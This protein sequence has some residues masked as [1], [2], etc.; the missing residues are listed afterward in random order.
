MIVIA[1]KTEKRLKDDL[2]QLAKSKPNQ[3]CFYLGLSQTDLP[4]KTVFET[5]LKTVDSIPNSYMAKI[6]LCQDKDIL[7]VMEG[8]MQRQFTAFA[9]TF[10]DTLNH[11]NFDH[12]INVYEVGR[13]W[14][15]LEKICLNKIAVLDRAEAESAAIS[16]DDAADVKIAEILQTLTPQDIAT[17]SNR[18]LMRENSLVMIADDDQLTRTLAGNVIRADYD[19]VFAQNGSKALKD[20]VRAAPDILFLDIGMPDIGGHDVLETLFQ[21]DP[22]AYIIMFSGR[23]DKSTIMKSL[24]MGAHGFLGKPFTR[25]QIYMHIENS[26]F[27]QANINKAG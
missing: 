9:G 15:T 4:R 13:H 25:D 6:Y 10:A 2:K 14:S 27:I 24:E 8:F 7:I 12:L 5:F 17:L 23:K 11:E 22:D 16:Q 19:L 26:P 18:R 20:Y 21:I 1:H 3:R